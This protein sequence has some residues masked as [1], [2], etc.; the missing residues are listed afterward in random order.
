MLI[1]RVADIGCRASRICSVLRHGFAG[2]Y[3]A[4]MWRAR[5]GFWVPKLR[6]VELRICKTCRGFGVGDEGFVPLGWCFR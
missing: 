1:R 4:D 6:V 5:H 2:A 3:V